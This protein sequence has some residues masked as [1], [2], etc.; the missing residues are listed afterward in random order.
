MFY[1]KKSKC[2]ICDKKFRVNDRIVKVFE[3]H[4][5]NVAVEVAIS[6]GRYFHLSHLVDVYNGKDK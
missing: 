1:Q 5:P 3:Y 4:E 6:S 2:I